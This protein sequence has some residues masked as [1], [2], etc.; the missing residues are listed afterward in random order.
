MGS[1]KKSK[2]AEFE[3][4]QRQLTKELATDKIVNIDD[5]IDV[6]RKTKQSSIYSL[7]TD[8][9]SLSRRNTYFLD[10][11]INH[12]V[13][14]NQPR[15]VLLQKRQHQNLYKKQRVSRKASQR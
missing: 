11:N 13:L 2:S 7:E 12:R 1:K 14:A 4:A 8:L 15:T 5:V 9:Q 3:E 10:L 6:G